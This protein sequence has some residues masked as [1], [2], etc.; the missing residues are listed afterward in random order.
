[1]TGPVG[2]VKR[3]RLPDG[4]EASNT[5]GCNS[6]IMYFLWVRSGKQLGE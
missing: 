1:M 5:G 6:D 3:T 4:V 2:L